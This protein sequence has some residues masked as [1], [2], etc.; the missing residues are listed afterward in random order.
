MSISFFES[1]S[2]AGADGLFLPIASL[3]GITSTELASAEPSSKKHSKFLFSFLYKLVSSYN[4]LHLGFYVSKLK[5]TVSNDF[6]NQSFVIKTQLVINAINNN[7]EVIPVPATGDNTGIGDFSLADYFPGASI[8]DST[9]NTSSA[10]VLIPIA[11]LELHGHNATGLSTDD[12]NILFSLI[13]LITHSDDFPVRS[14]SP[15]VN[16]AIISKSNGSY[17]LVELPASA[18]SL[19]NPTTGLLLANKERQYILER[20]YTFTIQLSLNALTTEINYA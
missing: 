13:S 5:P 7:I 4:P 14:S 17:A 18:Y 12:R 6:V 10:G 8:L 9:N 2:V 1:D 15:A 16:S 11:D 3:P 19:T 20:N